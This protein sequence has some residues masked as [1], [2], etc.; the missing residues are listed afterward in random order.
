VDWATPISTLVGGTIG[1]GSALL[2]DRL[3]VRRE[4][5]H[6][7]DDVRR[8]LYAK[9]LEALTSTDSDLQLLAIAEETPVDAIKV[10]A[11]W[12]KYSVLALKYEVQLVASR[13]VAEAADATYSRLRVMR[14]AIRTTNLIVGSP[15]NL[16]DDP[17]SDEWVAVHVPYINAIE[18][19]R[20]AMR[21]DIQRFQ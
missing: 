8:Q 3:R 2:G 12:R 5:M 4:R 14:N 18:D 10:R 20:R 11:V 7:I 1:I 13:V 19:L 16:D 21:A 6:Q 9:Y 17:G 15:G